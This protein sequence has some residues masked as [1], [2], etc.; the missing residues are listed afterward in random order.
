MNGT[1]GETAGD[2]SLYSAYWY[3]VGSLT[4]RLQPGTR[5]Q[6]QVL[7]GEEWFVFTHPISGQHYRLNRKA[8]ELIGRFNGEHT[9][10]SLWVGLQRVLGDEAPTQDEVIA[11][12]AQLL[13]FGLVL[14]DSLPD[15][16]MLQRYQHAQR[17][18]KRARNLNPFAFRLRLFNPEPLLGELSALKSI[19]M[20]PAAAWLWCALI[21]WALVRTALAWDEIHAYAKVHLLTPRC[22]FLAWAVY[23]VMKLLHELG[24]ALAVQ[25]WGGKVKEAGI[26]FFLLVPAPY[27]DA[28]AA[29]AFGS[30]WQRSAVSFAGI[31][32]ELALAALALGV[33]AAT[34]DGLVR[35]L[36]LVVMVIGGLSTILFNGN[37]LLRFD[38][39]YILCDLLELP[40]LASRSQN[41]WSRLTRRC[42]G[43]ADSDSG[44]TVSG[45]ERF[46]LMLYAP[47]S[48]IYRIAISVVIV[49]WV[50]TKSVFAGMMAMLWLGFLLFLRPLWAWLSGFS[51]AVPPGSQGRKRLAAAVCVTTALAGAL[52]FVPVP[53]STVATGVVWLPEQSQVRTES[54]GQV[55]AITARDGQQVTKGQPLVTLDAP[56]LLTEK[57]RLQ[58]RIAAADIEQANGWQKSPQQGRNAAD[59]LVR[60]RADLAQLDERLAG[61][62]LRAEVDGTF[63]MP[64]QDDLLG[65]H[66][67]KGTLIAYVL[68]R[69]SATVR[70]AVSQDDIGRIGAGVRAI[71]VHLAEIGSQYFD[72]RVL[73]MEPAATRK[74]PAK[75]IGDRGG[76]SLVTDPSDPDGMTTLEPVFLV[77]VQVPGYSVMQTGARAAVRFSY[78][79]RP[80]MESATWRLQQLFLR[81]FAMAAQ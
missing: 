6:R 5:I 81:I 4:P 61:L 27:V 79:P 38:G 2:R 57:R 34:E 30:K 49:Q 29:T 60:L 8:Y 63:V 18:R 77:D 39:Y 33:W 44:K 69:D 35:D 48:W 14:F 51:R 46:W 53:S 17:Q 50:V 32:I 47:A 59:Q 7:R 28:S 40:N 26:G 25:H 68:A 23:P 31:A 56:D 41:W 36:A 10:D 20:H 75:S 19:L 12:L 67:A 11:L 1:P 37:P 70:V 66:V 24:H 52:F 74:L 78:D 76:G 62:I 13:E 45:S 72:G 42:F 71:S 58:A 55:L 9:L 64:H 80:L 21:A 43:A 73:R 15:L 65:R 3:R 16:S 22:L 54:D